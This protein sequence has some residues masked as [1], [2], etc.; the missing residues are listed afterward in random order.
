MHLANRDVR[1]EQF[2]SSCIVD[3][4]GFL[5]SKSLVRIGID[6]VHKLKRQI[7]IDSLPI[8]SS[9]VVVKIDSNKTCD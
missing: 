6:A 4:G 1:S 3:R 8:K 5:L 7:E 9:G 2:A